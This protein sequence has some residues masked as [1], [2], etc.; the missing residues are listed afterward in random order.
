MQ[1]CENLKKTKTVLSAEDEKN[2]TT[3]GIPKLSDRLQPQ[4]FTKEPCFEKPQN[5]MNMA[6]YWR[7]GFFLVHIF[8]GFILSDTDFFICKKCQRNVIYWLY[9][10]WFGHKIHR[11]CD[12]TAFKINFSLKTVHPKRLRK[13]D[14]RN[15]Q[16]NQLIA[17]V[18]VLFTCFVLF[19]LKLLKCQ[20]F[21]F[22]YF[23]SLIC[24][25]FFVGK[26]N[27]YWVLFERPFFIR[28]R[29]SVFFIG[30]N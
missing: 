29:F 19:D 4:I 25:R 17:E 7:N 1:W 26:W 2:P 18:N 13:A 24:F 12:W 21:F 27:C 9:V 22:Y 3:D 11:L 14:N 15:S 16:L 30:R 23:Q 10:L 6:A 8:I 28:I 20:E 5:C